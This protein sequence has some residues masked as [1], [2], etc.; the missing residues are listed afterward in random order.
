MLK[1]NI[2]ESFN[3]CC[4]EIQCKIEKL[5]SFIEKEKKKSITVLRDQ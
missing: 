4:E 3:K 5:S 1:R 2:R